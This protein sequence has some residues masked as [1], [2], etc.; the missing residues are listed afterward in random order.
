MYRVGASG[1]RKAVEP[2]ILWGDAVRAGIGRGAHDTDV[3]WN[4]LSP[5]GTRSQQSVKQ[6]RDGCQQR[7]SP[8]N[9]EQQR[10]EKWR[11]ETGRDR[12]AAALPFGPQALPLLRAH[13]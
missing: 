6:G 2:K 8:E 11:H 10:Q 4:R 13:V 12:I 1:R 7:P 5:Q 3:P 9:G